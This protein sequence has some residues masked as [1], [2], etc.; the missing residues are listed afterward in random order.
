MK[1]KIFLLI[2]LVSFFYYQC[3][4]EDQLLFEPK[5]STVLQQKE[6]QIK[7]DSI[8]TSDSI[9]SEEETDPPKDKDPYIKR[10]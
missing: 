7:T 1:M 2:S 6:S 3:V 9:Q 4:D 8:P 5:N 10:M